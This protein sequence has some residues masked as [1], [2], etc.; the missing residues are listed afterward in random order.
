MMGISLFG[1]CT[2][3]YNPR[4]NERA[5][6]LEG[7][8]GLHPYQPESLAQGALELRRSLTRLP[9]FLQACSR[10]VQLSEREVVF[11]FSPGPR[12]KTRAENALWAQLGAQVNS[13]SLGPEVVLAE[14]LVFGWYSVTS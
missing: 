12:T 7:F 2:M 3:K 5:A 11:A 13:M 6:A 1:T 10:G 14:Y 8:R 4:V 9:R